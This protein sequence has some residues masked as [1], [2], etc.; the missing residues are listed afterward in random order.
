MLNIRTNMFGICLTPN[1]WLRYIAYITVR[2][3]YGL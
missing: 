2:P 1:I 3:I